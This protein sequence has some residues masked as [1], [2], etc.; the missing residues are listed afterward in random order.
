MQDGTEKLVRGGQMMEEDVQQ[1][2]A[3]KGREGKG[4]FRGARVRQFGAR[5]AVEKEFARW[6]CGGRGVVDWS[7]VDESAESD[8][9]VECAD[10]VL[11]TKVSKLIECFI[12]AEEDG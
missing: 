12:F 4:E 3:G 1:S 8:G 2:A 6:R 5:G 11:Q 9:W 10:F 7:K